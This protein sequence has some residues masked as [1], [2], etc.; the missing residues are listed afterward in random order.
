[1][2]I[3]E[4]I[5]IERDAPF[6]HLYSPGFLTAEICS[7]LYDYFETTDKWHLPEGSAPDDGPIWF[8][9][10]GLPQDLAFLDTPETI[11]TL[12]S[13]LG[14]IYGVAFGDKCELIA[15]KMSTGQGVRPHTDFHDEA[16]SHRIVIFIT[17]D[18]SW[19]AGGE[20][21]LLNSS[22]TQVQPAG[23]VL[24]P[25]MAGDAITFGISPQSYHTVQICNQGPRYSL[26]Y[27]FYPEGVQ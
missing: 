14:G 27:S 20:L 5:A 16:P 12:K 6:Q 23:H 18:W 25:P 21:L 2:S 9:N 19:D 13:W 24:Y 11:E 15:N 4:P 26:T 3:A 22:G 7:T 1:M 8:I 10:E 17:R